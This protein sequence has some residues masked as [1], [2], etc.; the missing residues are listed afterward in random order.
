MKIITNADDFGFDADTVR[1]TIA[2][3]E[4]GAL[5]GATI[6]PK[7]PATTEAISFARGRPEFSFGVHLTWGGDGIERPL[8]SPDRVPALVDADGAFLQ[9]N[10]VRRKALLGE[11][12]VEQI[13]VETEAQL[14]LVR[15]SG[16]VISHVDSHGHIHKF[17]P[18][19]A[20]LKKILPRFGIRR[21]RK[22]QNIYIRKPLKSPTFWLGPLWDRRIRSNFV[23][24]DHFFMSASAG[25]TNWVD[26]IVGGGW[27]GVLEIG[28]HPGTDEGNVDWRIAERQAILELA[29]KCRERNI[30]LMGWTS[31]GA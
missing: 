24:T 5:T 25:D 29:Q 28:V 6:M 11:I 12:P 27:S 13:E 30:S 1:A 15:D 31:L 7:M 2:C 3:L 21:V 18:F 14:A 8:S 22:V 16:V 19:V 9:S 10:I 20:A 23:T 26:R 4:A 17:K